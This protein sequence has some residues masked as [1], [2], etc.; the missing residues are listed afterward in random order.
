MRNYAQIRQYAAVAKLLALADALDAGEKPQI[1]RLL[2]IRAHLQHNS[3]VGI[4]SQLCHFSALHLANGTSLTQQHAAP[5]EA[6]VNW[7]KHIMPICKNYDEQHADSE[8]RR[9]RP[10][11]NQLS[12]L[13]N[14]LRNE[15][16]CIHPKFFDR[17]RS[18]AHICHFRLPD[19]E[20]AMLAFILRTG[21]QHYPSLCYWVA[22]YYCVSYS[23]QRYRMNENSAS[24]VRELAS[25]LTVNQSPLLN[26]C[27][28]I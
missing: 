11:E 16:L 22:Q 9:V 2:P 18:S 6:K 14:P 8:S 10:N 17:Q 24:R 19:P 26:Q 5:V 13:V 27:L 21:E 15:L 3:R 28:N 25:F 20:L 23:D 12:T 1:T 7:L 4:L